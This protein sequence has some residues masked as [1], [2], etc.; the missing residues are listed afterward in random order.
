MLTRTYQVDEEG[1]W[2]RSLADF[3]ED[4]VVVCS[5]CGEEPDGR[6]ESADNVFAFVTKAPH[7]DAEQPPT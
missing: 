7:R 5:G 1:R 6:V 3:A 2:L 4:V